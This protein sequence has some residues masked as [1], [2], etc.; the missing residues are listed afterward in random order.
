LVYRLCYK[1]FKSSYNFIS[2]QIRIIEEGLQKQN[3]QKCQEKNSEFFKI[4]PKN[5]PN[6]A[7]K[8]K[9][10]KIKEEKEVHFKISVNELKAEPN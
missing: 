6:E 8:C 3:H 7:E 10:A 5:S 1:R 2:S 4:Q 9:I